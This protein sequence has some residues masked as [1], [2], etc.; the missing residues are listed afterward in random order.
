MTGLS[1]SLSTLLPM[2]GELAGILLLSLFVSGV[3]ILVSMLDNLDAKTAMA[4]AAAR[5][6]KASEGLGGNFT[7]KNWATGTKIYRPDPLA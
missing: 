2:P 7:E 1:S 6:E 5:S 3:A 4:L